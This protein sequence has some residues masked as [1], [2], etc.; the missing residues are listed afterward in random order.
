M[1]TT[2][3]SSAKR[4]LAAIKNLQDKIDMLERERREPIAIIGMACRF[5]GG[6]DSPEAYWELLSGGRDATG[7]VPAARWD[8]NAYYD[9]DPSAPGKTYT[10]RGGFLSEVDRFDPHMF[11][12]S[13]REAAS[14]D[15]Q[16]RLVLELA[17]EALENANISAD[18]LYNSNTGVYVGISNT[19]YGAHLLWSGDPTRINAYAGT[20]GSLGVAAGRLSYLLGLTGPSLIVDTACSSSLV[21]THLACQSLRARECNVA[22]SAGVN[23]IFGPETFIN[24]S[25]AGMLS[26]DGRCKTFDAAADGYARG[27]G[28]GVVVLKRLSDALRDNDQVL[29]VIRGSAVNQDGPSGGLT[30][31]NGP[32]QTR[33]I[34]Q[35]LESGGV[36]PSQVGYI[37]A[38]GTGTA[39]GDPIEIRAL[40]NAYGQ[41]RDPA[42]PLLVGSVKTNFGHLESAAGIAGL[43]KAVLVLQHGQVPPHLHLK[44]PSPH[45]PWDELPLRVPTVLSPWGGNERYAGVSSF[46]F[47]GTNAHIV[48]AGA[49]PVV[50]AKPAKQRGWRLAP[51]SARDEGALNA[52]AAAWSAR[53]TS[54]S[55]ASWPEIAR[56]AAEGRAQLPYRL[57]LVADSPGMMAQ[58]LALPNLPLPRARAASGGVGKVAFLFT[59]QGSQYLG[60]GRELYQE[61]DVFRAALDECAALLRPRLSVSLIDLIYGDGDGEMLNATAHTQPVLFSVEYALMRLWQSWG[62]RPDAMLGHSVG[63]YAAACVAGVFSLDDAI[64]LIAERG[65]LMQALCAPGGMVAVPMSEQEVRRVI[66]PWAGEVA[67]ATLNGPRNVVVSSNP[68]AVAALADGLAASGIDARQLHVSHAFHSPMMEPMLSPFAAAAQAIKFHSP[69][70][71]IYSTLTGKPADAELSHADYWVRHVEAPVRFADGMRALLE[72]GYRIFVEVGPKPTLC[73]LGREIAESMGAE[74]A[75]ACVWLPSLRAGKP[76]WDTMLESLGHLWVRGAEIDW[77]ALNGPGSRHARLPNYPF[78]RRPYWIDWSI[79]QAMPAP[80]GS[81]PLLGA[82]LHTPALDENTTVFAGELNPDTAGLLAHHRIFGAVVLPAAAHMEIALAAAASL[83]PKNTDFAGLRIDVVDVAIQQALVLPEGAVTAVQI[84]LVARD[85]GFDF[86]I[87]SRPLPDSDEA[88]TLNTQ[89]RIAPVGLETASE[90]APMVDLPSLRARCTQ[91]LSVDDYYRRTHAAGI[92]HG[93]RFRALQDL[94]Q[95]DGLILARLCLPAEVANDAARFLLHPVLLDA[96][97]H[98]VGVPLMERGAPYLPVGMDALH[99]YHRP[100]TE[101][102]CVVRPRGETGQVFSADIEIMDSDGHLLAAV[103]N[104]RFQRVTQRALR[105]AARFPYSDWLYRMDW[106]QNMG[107]APQ[108]E[109]LPAPRDVADRLQPVMADAAASLG[110][111]GELFPGLDRLVAAYARAALEQLGVAWQ[112]GRTLELELDTLM[113]QLGIVPGY[114]RLLERLLVI[115]AEQG[116]LRAFGGGWSINDAA[117]DNPA[118][119]LNELS[120]NFPGAGNELALVARCGASLAQALDGRVGGLELLFPEGDMSMVTRFY[121]ESPGLDALNGL[122]RAAL[123]AVLERLPEGRMVRI[124]EIGGGTGSS[125]VHLLPH[126]PEERTQYLFTDVSAVFTGKARERFG[127][128]PFVSYQVLDIE[129]DPLTQGYNA[130][131]YDIVV[132]ANVLH[133]TRDLSKTLEH[134]NRLLAPG[135]ALLLLEGVTPQPWLDVTFG[136]TEGWWR[137]ADTER[138]PAYPLLNT[139]AWDTLL[140][141]C[142]FAA[143]TVISPDHAAGKALLRQAVMLATK[144]LAAA[145]AW[146]V[147]ADRY[148]IGVALTERMRQT[149]ARCEV[150]GAD[151][152]LTQ[153][154]LVQ[155]ISACTDLRGIVHARGLDSPLAS[156]MD[157]A[158]L[159]A[160]LQAGCRTALD[161]LQALTTAAPT[162]APQLVL[163]SHGAVCVPHY[164]HSPDICQAPLLAMSRVIAA[165]HPELHCTHIDLDPRETDAPRC[166][167]ALWQEIGFCS[168]EAVALRSA[169]RFVPRLQRMGPRGSPYPAPLSVR[170]DAMYLITGG[171][172]ELGLAAARWLVE[173]KGARLLTLVGRN[174]PGAAARAQIAAIEALGAKVRTVQADMT[175][176]AQVNALVAAAAREARLAGVIHAAGTMD[177]GVL[178]SMSWPRFAAVLAP[179]TMGAWN[180]H[181]AC[182]RYDLDFFVLY[183][184]MAAVLGPTA[185]ANYAAANAFLDALSDFRRN[186]G[187]PAMSIN[188]GAW[189]EIGL[190]A[191]GTS[192]TQLDARG[193][194]RI[195]PEQ[196]LSLLEHLL[197]HPMRHV[198][199]ASIDWERMLA[200][201]GNQPLFEHFQAEAAARPD[202]PSAGAPLRE[203][204]AGLAVGEQR[205]LTLDTVKTEVARILGLES[206]QAVEEDVGFFEIGMDSLTAVELRNALQTVVGASLP[207]T[208]LFKYSTVQTLT[209]F[210]ADEILGLAG[211]ATET[212]VAHPAPPTPT[213]SNAVEEVKGMSDAELSAMID[214]ELAGF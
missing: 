83:S 174:E 107:C 64:G 161:L 187:L 197:D 128:Y 211:N 175:D 106:E 15:P 60:M 198:L 29:A 124:L 14:I 43:I 188:W 105:G 20:G 184:S 37:E 59:G 26:P 71:R 137:F 134:V 62:L 172:G 167:D 75:Q 52:L 103:E 34:R 195:A 183:S 115:L 40:G 84:V 13:P 86:R 138:R 204:L 181:R 72:D 16:H 123:E 6:A 191:R 1:S 168:G 131:G 127:A 99:R 154:L 23:L 119:L 111:Y 36:T 140:G 178:A 135:G 192:G 202:K 2:D 55:P 44:Q 10:R 68:L 92:E 139:T 160:A 165:E 121:T 173:E 141:E 164:A 155:R 4:A 109:W 24:F 56:T 118:A 28:G 199:A 205:A 81:H 22:L 5:P 21:T 126:L 142:G 143:M 158:E 19:E 66:Q 74:V 114:R 46:S 12:I 179:K 185:Q 190:V 159:E 31:P 148:G 30:V 98:M 151:E 97:F 214:A 203:R 54:A 87:Y 73:A 136:L 207:T 162:P 32:A 38:H 58:R 113:Q 77:G 133:A 94:W 51:L 212:A 88:W 67:V 42:N 176:A 130:A 33:V 90:T 169:E 48:L 76:S 201:Y 57:A 170:D 194:G 147:L 116:Q 166:A 152:T 78:Q 156:W 180:L 79:G 200:Q 25:K 120:A 210:L 89:G 39:L 196:G 69:T 50:A 186:Q 101:V 27:E 96:A 129:N 45:I 102:W 122:L 110:W 125:T 100:P 95:G 53:L 93:E 189:S 18:R 193:M 149:G 145:G 11:G 112:A 206:A 117:A 208:L 146:L 7:E 157:A 3:L 163:V 144:P 91:A 49:P 61:S 9:P 70:T 150:I 82:R 153:E 17:W 132:A 104:L 65:R 35:A 108:A 85:A 47:S 63:E 171:L 8:V 177:D 182:V 41:G 213:T 209:R 80:N